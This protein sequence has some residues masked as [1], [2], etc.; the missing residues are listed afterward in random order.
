MGEDLRHAVGQPTFRARCGA[1]LLV[2]YSLLLMR[3]RL[4]THV[5]ECIRP[6]NTLHVECGQ[7]GMRTH[8]RSN[9]AFGTPC[10][11]ADHGLIHLGPRLREKTPAWNGRRH[12]CRDLA[13]GPPRI[14]T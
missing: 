10:V 8:A 7:A 14:A 11:G 13:S 4:A 5:L 2:H 12:G 1:Q 3:P 9:F 6:K